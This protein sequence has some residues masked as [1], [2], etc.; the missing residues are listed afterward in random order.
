[1]G[2]GNMEGYVRSEKAHTLQTVTLFTCTVCA[3]ITKALTKPKAITKTFLTS[4][5]C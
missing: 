3:T 1:M 4:V 2:Y 5:N